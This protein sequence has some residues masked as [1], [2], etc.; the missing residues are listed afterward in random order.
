MQKKYLILLKETSKPK[1]SSWKSKLKELL[2]EFNYKTKPVS[3][4]VG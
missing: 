1:N 4:V 2:I 3:M